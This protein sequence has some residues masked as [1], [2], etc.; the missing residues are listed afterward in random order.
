MAAVDVHGTPLVEEDLGNTMWAEVLVGEELGVV[1]LGG[2]F[3]GVDGV[4]VDGSYGV[5]KQQRTT[6]RR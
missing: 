1:V 6:T 2:P 3:F 5:A 4:L